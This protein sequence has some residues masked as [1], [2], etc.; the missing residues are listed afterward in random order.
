VAEGTPTFDFD[1]A[2]VGAGPAGLTAALVLG[3]MRRRVLLIDSDDPAHAVTEGVHGFLGHDGRAPGELRG[4]G[5][6]QLRP[7]GSVEVRE[8]LVERAERVDGGFALAAGDAQPVRARVLLL[9]AGMRYLTP[10]IP[11]MTAIW[12]RGAYH[13]PY[14]HGWE[15]RDRPLAAYGSG[16]GTVNQALL[17]AS[18][19]DDVTLF[20]SDEPGLTADDRRRLEDAGVRVSEAGLDR[21]DGDEEEVRLVLADG[22]TQGCGG[23]FF[24][25][26]FEPSPLGSQLG[27]ERDEQGALVTDDDGRTSVPGLFGAGDATASK[28]AVSLAAASGSRAAFAINAELAGAG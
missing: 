9:A 14:C 4:L 16:P 21:V 18:L 8:A 25:P 13:C 20:P 7:Y 28:K 22:S 2:I 19:S 12:G 10:D 11:G 3:R 17:L 6:E 15:V 1:V 26:A 27:C 24:N 23:L 5:R